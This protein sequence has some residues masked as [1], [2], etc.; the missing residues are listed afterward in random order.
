MVIAAQFELELCE[1]PQSQWLLSLEEAVGPIV[2]D[3]RVSG[4]IARGLGFQ[5]RSSAEPGQHGM[6]FGLPEIYLA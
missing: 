3:T 2:D 4:A 5:E 1:I 6:L